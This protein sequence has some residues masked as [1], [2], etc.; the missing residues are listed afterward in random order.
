MTEEES[1]KTGGNEKIQKWNLKVEKKC[2]EKESHNEIK[3]KVFAE[4]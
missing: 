1:L 4:K 2:Y 3:E